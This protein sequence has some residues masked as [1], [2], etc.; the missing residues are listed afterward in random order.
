MTQKK[1][2]NNPNPLRQASGDKDDKVL[3]KTSPI[4][5]VDL[6][7]SIFQAP[8]KKVQYS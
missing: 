6:G 4:H 7:L 8:T 1:M 2:R 3:I 5:N